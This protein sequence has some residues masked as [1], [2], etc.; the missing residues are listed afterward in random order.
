MFINSP[1][2]D[3][4]TDLS[5]KLRQIGASQEVF[6]LKMPFSTE[7]S[8]SIRESASRGEPRHS[9]IDR[10]RRRKAYACL[11]ILERDIHVDIYR[12]YE[13]QSPVRQDSARLHT[14][15]FRVALPVADADLSPLVGARC[16][17][18]TRGR[19]PGKLVP[20]FRN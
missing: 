5:L 13:I 6:S 14:R 8:S 4:K 20:S 7:Q 15:L 1:C 11:A 2:V 16:V 12:G 17:R 18:V 3:L 9:R 10:S 19:C